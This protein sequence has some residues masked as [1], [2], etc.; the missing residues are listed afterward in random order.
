[1]AVYV[2]LLDLL[3]TRKW[4]R[5]CREHNRREQ[6]KGGDFGRYHPLQNSFNERIK[7]EATGVKGACQRLISEAIKL[8]L[9][10]LLILCLLV[11]SIHNFIGQLHRLGVVVVTMI[12]MGQHIPSNFLTLK[13]L[14]ALG[15]CSYS[16]YLVHWPL[17]TLH[18]YW[19]PEQYIHSFTYP[20]YTGCLKHQSI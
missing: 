16:V 17:F 20:T 7:L 5:R 9:I 6:R 2:W 19:Y 8:F 3:S 1:M 4:L 14:I 11:E 15:D 18:R 12:I 10:A 13:P